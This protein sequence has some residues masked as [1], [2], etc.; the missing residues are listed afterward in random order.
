LSELH[1][2]NII[3]GKISSVNTIEDM[4]LLSV[5]E[6][7]RLLG[8][9]Y[10]SVVELIERGEL[11]FIEMGNRKKIPMIKLRSFI[12]R[13]SKALKDKRESVKT[14]ERALIKNKIKNIIKKYERN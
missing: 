13:S 12:N 14:F 10:Q 2:E 7:R 3:D 5:N 6:A 8:I 9:R 1:T 4:R 11:E